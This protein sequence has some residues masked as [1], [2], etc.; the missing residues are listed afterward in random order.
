M[1][2]IATTINDTFPPASMLRFVEFFSL[3]QRNGEPQKTLENLR[4]PRLNNLILLSMPHGCPGVPGVESRVE[5]RSGG[6][7]PMQTDRYTR[8][9]LT[10]I[11]AALVWI[12]LRDT[13]TPAFAQS[14]PIDVNITAV[15]GRPIRG[16]LPVRV[17]NP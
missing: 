16:E 17:R 13:A 6:T 2:T 1:T 12:C 11:A 9:V 4:S 14:G 5:S 10:I 7:K 3:V 15:S 8:V